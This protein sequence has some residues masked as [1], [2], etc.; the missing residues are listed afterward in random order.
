[1]QQ[2]TEQIRAIIQESCNHELS[3]YLKLRHQDG[4]ILTT[5][6]QIIGDIVFV[7]PVSLQHLELPRTCF[8]FQ[9]IES[10]T[11]AKIFHNATLYARV[12]DLKG[13]LK[14]IQDRLSTRNK[15]VESSLQ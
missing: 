13:N 4:E 6:R 12:R 14:I 9:E 11:V 15:L 5:P 7:E 3:L 1:M 10:A 8:Y 2:S